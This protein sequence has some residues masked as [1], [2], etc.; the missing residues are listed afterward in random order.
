MLLIVDHP[1]IVVK[2]QKTRASATIATPW[3]TRPP[4]PS[5]G[6]ARDDDDDPTRPPPTDAASVPTD[7]TLQLNE[8]TT[9]EN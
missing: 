9:L 3:R 2:T 7:F 4:Y 8:S 1:L 6:T 5:R